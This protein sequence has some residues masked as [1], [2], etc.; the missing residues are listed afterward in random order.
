MPRIATWDRARVCEW[1]NNKFV[2]HK[3]SNKYCSKGCSDE[4]RKKPRLR[5]ACANCGIEFAPRTQHI[6]RNV[7]SEFCCSIKCRAEYRTGSRASYFKTG[8]YTHVDGS[9]MLGFGKQNGASVYVAEHRIIVAKLLGRKLSAGEVVI[10]VSG[11]KKDNRVSN[12]YLCESMSHYARIRN[13]SLPW[14]KSSNLSAT[15]G[16]S[17]AEVIQEG[18]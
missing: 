8:T 17:N 15:K 2:A 1:C 5:V 3:P 18:T 11:D 6:R 13:G 9:K 7:S 10:H 4:G 14:P 12:L 16:A